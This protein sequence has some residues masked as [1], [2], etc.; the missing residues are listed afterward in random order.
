MS[1]L[2]I[3]YIEKCKNCL[4]NP[5]ALGSQMWLE[6]APMSAP[7]EGAEVQAGCS[8]LG[9]CSLLVGGCCRSG[10]GWWLLGVAPSRWGVAPSRGRVC[11]LPVGARQEPGGLSRLVFSLPLLVA[12]CAYFLVVSFACFVIVLPQAAT[13]GL[14]QTARRIISTLNYV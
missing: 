8:S 10:G 3:I 11:S 12:L 6:K 13:D 5:R 14:C 2:L 4:E 7:R 9:C 1:G